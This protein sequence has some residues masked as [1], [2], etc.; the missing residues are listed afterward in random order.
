MPLLY[1]SE[2][3]MSLS[4]AV[5]SLQQQIIMYGG[6]EGERHCSVH[7]LQLHLTKPSISL[8]HVSVQCLFR[9]WVAL[10]SSKLVVT[11]VDYLLSRFYPVSSLKYL[12]LTY[13]MNIS[14]KTLIK[15]GRGRDIRSWMLLRKDFC[16]WMPSK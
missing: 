14:Y 1:K 9:D 11:K 5:C 7:T 15:I 8:L 2:P 6:R 4:S 10:L 13:I 16:L 12:G 3:W